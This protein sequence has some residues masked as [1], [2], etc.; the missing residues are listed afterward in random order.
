MIYQPSKG[1]EFYISLQ[2][3]KGLV[4][5]VDQDK[6]EITVK[7]L[8]KTIKKTERVSNLRTTIKKL[9]EIVL[10]YPDITVDAEDEDGSPLDYDFPPPYIAIVVK[11]K[12]VSRLVH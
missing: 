1:S 3:D 10:A 2:L 8:V 7:A 4:L 6:L 12:L 9:E 5:L 11:A